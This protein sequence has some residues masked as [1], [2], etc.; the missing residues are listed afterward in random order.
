MNDNQP[1]LPDRIRA[2]F[3]NLKPVNSPPSLHTINGV[4][5][6]IYGKRDFDEET[7]TYVKT[8]CICLLFIPIIAIDAWRVADAGS[9]SWYFLGKD[10]LSGFAKS[11][12]ML[13]VC[14]LLF[15]G[16]SIGWDA[17]TSS[18]EYRARQE[19]KRAAAL[20]QA[21]E[22][23]KAAGIYREQLGGPAAADA[24]N[25]LHDAIETCLKSDQPQTVAAAYR[26]LAALPANANQPAPLVPDAFNRGLVLVEKFRAANADGALE[27]LEADA[28]LA[29]TNT[30]LTALRIDLLKQVVAANPDNT[31]RVV[32]LAVAYENAQQLDAGVALLRPYQ[33]RLGATEG[34]RILG[35]KLLS[36]QNYAAAYGLLFP[37]VQSRLGQ[38]R[39]VET[40]YSN[41]VA[42]AE[43]QILADLNNGRAGSEF[44]RNYKA[45]SKEKQ[46]EM[47]DDYIRSRMKSNPAIQRAVADLKAANRIVP[48][49]LD[50]GIVQLNRAQELRDPAARK[51]E[52]EAAEKTFLAIRGFAGE[53]DEYRL[54]L[55]QVYYWLG[56]SKEGRELFDQLLASRNRDYSTLMSIGNTLRDVGEQTEARSLVEEAYNNG[57]NDKQ[58]FNAAAFRSVLF[59]DEDDRMAWLQKADTNSTLIQIELNN[60]RGL[61][62]LQQGNKPLAADYLRKAVAGYEALPKSSATLNN[63]AL[64]CFS[65]YEATGSAADQQRG[66]SMIEEAVAMDPGDSILLHNTTYFLIR[67]AVLDVNRDTVNLAALGAKP[68]LDTLPVL[69]RDEFGRA[70]IYRQLQDTES[71]KKAQGYLDKA[72][73]LAPKELDLYETALS[74]AGGFRDLPALQKLQQR[75][76][77]ASPDLA[78]VKRSTIEAYSDV[79]DQEHLDKLQKRI[80]S[81]AEAA[82]PFATNGDLATQDYADAELNEMQ[83]NAWLLGGTVDAAALLQSA[84]S[85]S[86]RHPSA[87][88]HSTL[89]A[90]YLFLAHQQLMRD[91]PD[92][93]ALAARTRHALG[94][95]YLISFVLEHGGPL[96]EAARKNENVVQAIARTKAS[97]QDFPGWASVQE[98]ALLR[99]S[100]PDAAAEVTKR[101]KENETLRLMDTLQFQFNPWN[102]S[103]VLEH[104]WTQRMLGDEQNAA[105]ILQNAQR[106]GVPLPAL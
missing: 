18:P 16:L 63:G 101:I 12:N 40:G 31:N 8:R 6:S 82:R 76:Q 28:G 79:K 64:V 33:A 1:Q 7:Q 5:V 69:Y 39:N 42:N 20:Q 4:G 43:R 98:W 45:A 30:A 44:Y 36:E 65:L 34:A 72:L 73:L 48:V 38:L 68:G 99:S 55:G 15:A 51:A 27:I 106:D 14:V 37:Y 97:L 46:E 86:E 13:M 71:M 59:K 24:H 67:R 102:A 100:D 66:L 80:R 58:K 32:E 54:F 61:K 21:G 17:H 3:P 2:K 41:T 35:Q 89:T 103:L 84:R 74:L 26:L 75:F 93:A 25:G 60:G 90:S 96:A 9:R 50:L 94:A 10:S 47:V 83:Q 87:T 91:Y 85:A 77:I 23:L 49:A 29:P 104:Y 78:E 22:P 92:Y 81:F 105:Q 62:A 53:S 95:T 56:K 57:K 88:S 52:L 11:W 19:I 70:Q